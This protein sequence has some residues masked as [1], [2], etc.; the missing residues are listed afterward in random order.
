MNRRWPLTGVAVV[1]AAAAGLAWFA[2]GGMA[3]TAPALDEYR[4]PDAQDIPAALA[5]APDQSVWFTLES[6]D[7][8]GVLRDGQIQKVPRGGETLEALGLATDRDGG[9]WVTDITGQSIKHVSTDG[10]HESIAVPGPLAQLGRLTVGPDG[11]VWFADGWGNSVTRLRDGR[12][13]PFAAA[14]VNAAPF[15]VAADGDGTIWATLQIANKLM[16][17]DRGGAPTELDLPSHN[18]TPTDIAID[19]TGGVWFS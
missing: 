10:V 1:L 13:E 18:A 17:I 2:V 11:S 12:L 16:R 7:A 4:V 6:S 3:S 19:A 14:E 8:I 5:L 15:G 9:A